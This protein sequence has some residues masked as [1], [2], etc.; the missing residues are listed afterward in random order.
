MSGAKRKYGDL[1][2]KKYEVSNSSVLG[3]DSLKMMGRDIGSVVYGSQM[4]DKVLLYWYKISRVENFRDFAKFVHGR[5]NF[6][7]KGA[8]QS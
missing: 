7:L 4:S 1:L 6:T 5:E 2:S 8:I 3:V